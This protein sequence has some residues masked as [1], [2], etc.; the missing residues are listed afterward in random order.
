MMKT[1]RNLFKACVVNY[2]INLFKIVMQIFPQK[3]GQGQEEK[4]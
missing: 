1:E 3:I 4:T 2:F